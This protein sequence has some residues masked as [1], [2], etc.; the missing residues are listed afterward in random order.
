[1]TS[2]A[3]DPVELAAEM[4]PDKPPNR[5]H[6]VRPQTLCRPP[7]SIWQET[8]SPVRDSEIATDRLKKL[9]PVRDKKKSK[10]YKLNIKQ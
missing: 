2:F 4:V 7:N 9:T 10:R 6:P 3:D 5:Q 1:M 8:L